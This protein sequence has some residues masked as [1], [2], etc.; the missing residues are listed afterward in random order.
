MKT[1]DKNKYVLF[2][3]SLLP[4]AAEMYMGFMHMGISLLALFFAGFALAVEFSG[5]DGLL[6]IPAL[7][8]FFGFFHAR[9]L[10]SCD[11]ET[12]AATEDRYIWDEF[13]GADVFRVTPAV[14]RKW[15][16]AALILG[17]FSM[18]WESVSGTI[19][20]LFNYMYE[21]FWPLWHAL[22]EVPRV[23]LSLLLIVLGFR[24]VRGKKKALEEAEREQEPG[25]THITESEH[26][27]EQEQA[28]APLPALPESTEAD[29]GE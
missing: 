21:D 24:L 17:G 14:P 8:W 22:N 13:F 4:G 11:E 15:I 7:I 19:M 26:F 1:K 5:L 25:Q 6:F 23:F 3:F 20:D 10:C 2:L 9:N 29:D 16:A 27:P 28:E 18:L 12:F